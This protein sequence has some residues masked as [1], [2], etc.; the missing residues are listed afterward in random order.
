MRSVLPRSIHRS[1]S[2]NFA[3]LGVANDHEIVTINKNYQQK[4]YYR[5][6]LTQGKEKNRVIF[7][8]A[9]NLVKVNH[10]PMM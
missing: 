2:K 6:K 7:D 8:G 5:V 3:G 1:I 10:Q 4:I 9:G